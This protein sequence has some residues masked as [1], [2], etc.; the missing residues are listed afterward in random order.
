MIPA[1]MAL[2]CVIQPR[3][4]LKFHFLLE[5]TDISFLLIA[6]YYSGLKYLPLNLQEHIK[7]PWMYYFAVFLTSFY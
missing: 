7:I 5:F 2:F 3:L 1:F 4:S 6:G